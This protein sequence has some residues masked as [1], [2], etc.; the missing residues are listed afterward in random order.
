MQ[1][2][3]IR[4]AAVSLAAML[5]L[6]GCG[7][8]TATT[9]P[10][11]DGAAPVVTDS[12]SESA[13]VASSGEM[14]APEELN[15]DGLTPV[16]V[17][18]LKD[19]EYEIQVDSS[20]SMFKI[21]ACTLTVDDGQMIARMTMGGTGYLRVYMGTGEQ[22]A[23]AAESDCIPYE[24]NADGTHSFTVPVEALNKA[25]DCA[26]FSKNKEKWYERQ[27][28]FRADDLPEEA[29][30]TSR[31]TTAE[32]LGLEDGDYTAP[33]TLAGG[34]GRAQVES[35]AKL[36]LENGQ[37]T[38]TIVWSSSNYDY[39]KMDGEKFELENAEGNSTFVIPVKGF[40]A[41]L[42]VLAD[43]VAMSTPHEIEYTLTFDSSALQ[44][45]EP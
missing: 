34:S 28:V 37:L 18:Q 1:K 27:L 15:T 13:Q 2:I 17:D 44:K 35:P 43:T 33:V 39:M 31:Y 38:A 42:N 5:I 29:Y 19:G 12:A 22:A 25:I 4:A 21:T 41:P 10:M 3:S 23:A 32:A 9:L 7:S 36:H 11:P 8:N 30:L 40:D 24:E 6:T 20:S 26:A 14:A 16:T 45:V